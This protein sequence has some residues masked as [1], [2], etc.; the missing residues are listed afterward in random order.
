MFYRKDL[1]NQ[2]GLAVPRTFDELE[3]AAKALTGGGTYGISLRGKFALPSFQPFLFGYGAS[4]IKGGKPGFSTPEGVTALEQ[5]ARIMQNYAPPG[6]SGFMWQEN[7]TAFA[8][9]TAAMFIDSVSMN[10]WVADPGKSKVVGKFGVAAVPAGPAGRFTWLGN[11]SVNVFKGSKKKKASWLFVQWSTGLDVSRDL[12]RG[13]YASA[14]EAVWGDEQ[15]RKNVDPTWMEAMKVSGTICDQSYVP[16]IVRA[17]EG[18]EAIEHEVTA[19][20]EKRKD[21]KTALDDAAK[22]VA[23]LL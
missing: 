9:E 1:L 21:A 20:I 2:K 17:L 6:A 13:G 22:K 12:L 10:S 19:V 15:F 8:Q 5:Y 16:D 7:V 14:V 18:R 4:F 23:D 11:W 3:N